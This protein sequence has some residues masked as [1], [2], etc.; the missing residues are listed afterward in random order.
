MSGLPVVVETLPRGFAG[1]RARC[2]Q[3]HFDRDGAPVN[4][5]AAFLYRE[6][7]AGTYA[8]LQRVVAC[9]AHAPSWAQTLPDPS[10]R[11][12]GPRTK[13]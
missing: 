13:R 1:H 8:E 3:P 6:L 9:R 4:G 2:P 12:R 5:P 7:E 11:S 10:R